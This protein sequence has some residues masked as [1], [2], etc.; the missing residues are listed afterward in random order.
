MKIH[1]E[2][3]VGI[4]ERKD[5][6]D[7]LNFT[8]ESTIPFVPFVGMM[9]LVSKGDMFREVESVFWGEGKAL[10]VFFKFG[11]ECDA[12]D[13]KHLRKVGWKEVA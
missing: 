5:G 6:I 2:L 4:P 9:L 1:Y 7:G 3:E 10:R 8:I 12:A 13:L 11:G